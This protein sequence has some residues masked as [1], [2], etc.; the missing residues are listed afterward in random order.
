[1]TQTDKFNIKLKLVKEAV[2]YY[3]VLLAIKNCS[4]ELQEH[5]YKMFDCIVSLESTEEDKL[6]AAMTLVDMLFPSL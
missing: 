1:M 4:S 3:E 6:A 5:A 2:K